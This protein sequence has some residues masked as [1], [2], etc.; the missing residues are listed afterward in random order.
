MQITVKGKNLAVSDNVRDE[1]IEKLSKVK[2]VFD[3]ILDIQVVF[4]QDHNP[5]IVDKVHCEVTFHVK[6]RMMRA[7]A[8]APDPHTAIDR[9]QAKVIRQARGH[10]NKMIDSHRAKREVS[11][12][13]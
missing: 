7:S 3:R 9:V 5:R 12:L 11:A 4:T 6:G 2:Q 13:A 10:K 1:A 8:T